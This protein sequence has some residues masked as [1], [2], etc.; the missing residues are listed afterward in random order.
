MLLTKGELNL[1]LIVEED[2]DMIVHELT[3]RF[4]LPIRRAALASGYVRKGYRYLARYNGRFGCGITVRYYTTISTRFCNKETFIFDATPE[5][6]EETIDYCFRKVG[7]EVVC[8]A[9]F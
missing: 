1:G 7:I 3:E 4:G 5:E 8:R 2:V 6:I 9:M